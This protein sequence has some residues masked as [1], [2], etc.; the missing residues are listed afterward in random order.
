MVTQSMAIKKE[1]TKTTNKAIEP[2]FPI[3][4]IS[5]IT[6]IRIEE[7]KKTINMKRMNMKNK[8]TTVMVKL[9]RIIELKKQ[10][11]IKDKNRKKLNIQSRRIMINIMKET[12]LIITKDKK[13]QKI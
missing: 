4:K 6:K 2:S 9:R 10:T 12:I 13:K 8:R 5:M 3:N 7:I 11:L 1:M